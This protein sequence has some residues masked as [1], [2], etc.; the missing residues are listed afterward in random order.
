MLGEKTLFSEKGT[1]TKVATVK[2][3]PFTAAGASHQRRQDF[4]RSSGNN[5]PH[6]ARTIFNPEPAGG[7]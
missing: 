2:T 5:E 4:K 7:S 6:H 3:S 1:G